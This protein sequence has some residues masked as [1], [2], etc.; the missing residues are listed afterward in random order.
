MLIYALYFSGWSIMGWAV[1]LMGPAE[2]LGMKQTWF[3]WAKK[4]LPQDS[5]VEPG[6][7][8][9]IRHPVY[10]GWLIVFWASPIMSWG[11]LGLAVGLT[12]YLGLA[13]RW[14]E[15]DL[16]AL[17]GDAYRNY[18]KRVPMLVPFFRGWPDRSKARPERTGGDSKS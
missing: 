5:M 12:L 8:R 11:H 1:F 4:T 2:M 7:Y 14:E 13:I 9:Y 3:H 18:R 16:L 15:R 10:L 6:P 17:H